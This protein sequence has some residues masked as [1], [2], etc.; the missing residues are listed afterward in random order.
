[1]N[2]TKGTGSWSQTSLGTESLGRTRAITLV[3]GA[4]HYEA[5]N[6]R[7]NRGSLVR[8][9]MISRDRHPMAGQLGSF[10]EGTKVAGLEQYSLGGR[11]AAAPTLFVS[12]TH[13]S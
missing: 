13:Q 9:A 1:M 2:Q 10:T 7:E 4:Q 3:L 6:S 11:G 12:V 5:Q 8:Q